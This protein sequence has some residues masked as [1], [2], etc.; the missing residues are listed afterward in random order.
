MGEDIFLKARF[1]DPYDIQ[2]LQEAPVSVDQKI[3]KQKDGLFELTATL[4]DTF[5]LRW[6]LR[7]YGDEVEVLA[8]EA[9]RQE[10][11]EM[12]R[13]FEKMYGGV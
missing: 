8:P 13:E 12:T 2:R 10:F 6:W 5:Q 11:V 3:H 1:S 4:A 9:L 7:G